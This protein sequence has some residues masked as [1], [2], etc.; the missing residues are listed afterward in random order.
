MFLLIAKGIKHAS[1]KGYSG[2]IGFD[3]GCS[4]QMLQFEY[5]EH[6]DFI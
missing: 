5:H 2:I 6:S 3:N 1:L 4:E